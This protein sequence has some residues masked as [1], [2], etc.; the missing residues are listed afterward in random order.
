ML[1]SIQDATIAATYAM[2]SATAL[3]LGTCWVGA[4]DDDKV[5]EVVG[6]SK[7]LVPVAVITIGYSAERPEITGRRKIE[8]MASIEVLEKP[9]PHKEVKKELKR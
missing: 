1:Y 4:F 8:E 2:L 6:A 9:F 5:R 3:D 7:D